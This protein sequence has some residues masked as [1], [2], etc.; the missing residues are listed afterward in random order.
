MANFWWLTFGGAYC[1][2]IAQ[3]FN[4]IYLA[5]F[6]AKDTMYLI[7]YFLAYESNALILQLLQGDKSILWLVKAHFLP[8]ILAMPFAFCTR[9]KIPWTEFAESAETGQT[10]KMLQEVKVQIYNA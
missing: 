3:N 10:T 2:I 1:L 4:I 9:E 5:I 6:K 8:F 7:I